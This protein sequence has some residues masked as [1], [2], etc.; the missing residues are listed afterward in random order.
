M[1][2]VSIFYEVDNYETTPH[3]AH[4]KSYMRRLRETVFGD[5][6][7]GIDPYIKQGLPMSNPFESVAA[8]LAVRSIFTDARVECTLPFRRL[9][10][11]EGFDFLLNGRTSRAKDSAVVYR[12]TVAQSITLQTGIVLGVTG[13]VFALFLV[14]SSFAVRRLP[15]WV[16]ANGI[17]LAIM[18][19]C[20]YLALLGAY[21]FLLV[22]TSANHG[23]DSSLRTASPIRATILTGQDLR[24]LYRGAQ[25]LVFAGRGDLLEDTL[26]LFHTFQG[27]EA[28][29]YDPLYPDLFAYKWQAG[30]EVEPLRGLDFLSLSTLLELL[31]EVEADYFRAQLENVLA[32]NAQDFSSWAEE[33]AEALLEDPTT[34]YR[35]LPRRHRT[36]LLGTFYSEW[37]AIPA[38]AMKLLGDLRKGMTYLIRESTDLESRTRLYEEQHAL[39][40]SYVMDAPQEFVQSLVNAYEHDLGESGPGGPGGA[41]GSGGSG[42]SPI[43]ANFS[44]LHSTAYLGSDINWGGYTERLPAATLL[45]P[46]ERY[47]TALE[48]ASL[49]LASA[50]TLHDFQAVDDSFTGLADFAYFLAKSHYDHMAGE[51][52]YLT[53]ASRASISLLWVCVVYVLVL[54]ALLLARVHLRFPYGLEEAQ[55]YRLLTRSVI[56]GAWPAAR[57]L[58]LYPVIPAVLLLA[59]CAIWLVLDYYLADLHDAQK[60]LVEVQTLSSSAHFLGTL[61]IEQ[62]FCYKN[63]DCSLA[64]Y[65]AL[66]S[67][68]GEH[69]E[70]IQASLQEL[71]DMQVLSHASSPQRTYYATAM[72]HKLLRE[73]SDTSHLHAMETSVTGLGLTNRVFMD[74]YFGEHEVNVS[75]AYQSLVSHAVG[76]GNVMAA[77]TNLGFSNVYLDCLEISDS[78][79]STVSMPGIRPSLSVLRSTFEGLQR[80]IL[81]EQQSPHA[82]LHIT[83]LAVPLDPA[84]GGYYRK[85]TN[86]D[87]IVLALSLGEKFYRD[88]MAKLVYGDPGASLPDPDQPPEVPDYEQMQSEIKS[89]VTPERFLDPQYLDLMDAVE[90]YATLVDG[91]G[92][93]LATQV[94]QFERKIDVCIIVGICL[95]LVLTSLTSGCL[96]LF[97]SIARKVEIFREVLRKIPQRE[98]RKLE[99]QYAVLLHKRA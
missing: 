98:F 45:P 31:P 90:E 92:N 94:E 2:S 55:G 73:I 58:M 50:Q 85:A 63:Q 21:I 53:A 54:T 11:P 83:G 8:S 27:F 79:N 13:V 22:Q 3:T 12:N 37:D 68:I 65:T 70:S 52:D 71:T 30:Q 16:H 57:A 43:L 60:L 14:F 36:L 49:V 91:A 81:G 40:F 80:S 44:F 61:V 86:L 41:G 78:G 88:R 39:G 51:L 89:L 66:T 6:F 9:E 25:C 42:D 72:E 1:R 84:S 15:K 95:V 69:I 56:S 47:A 48:A 24:R 17:A 82:M 64:R 23:A 74:W 32:A 26:T 76:S 59:C 46:A 62:Y 96:L 35:Y 7:S 10:D 5:R 77:L 20:V 28:L 75:N 87:D 18:C 33:N 93:E 29:S 38:L 99:P 34:V 4:V 19:G 67:E 97:I